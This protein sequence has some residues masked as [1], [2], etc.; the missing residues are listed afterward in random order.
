MMSSP[1]LLVSR[2]FPAYRWKLRSQLTQ[3]VRH[4]SSSFKPKPVK[5]IYYEDLTA[6]SLLR[7]CLQSEIQEPLHIVRRQVDAATSIRLMEL[8]QSD[9]DAQRC[10]VELEV[11]RYDQDV[12]KVNLPLI[13][14]LDWLQDSPSHGGKMNGKQVYLAQ[15]RGIDDVRTHCKT[16]RP[17]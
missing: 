2:L 3:Q 14:Y 10:I 17:G 5:K 15:W 1:L 4:A 7:Q 11:G 9:P 8:L 13:Q 16:T 6:D 12:E